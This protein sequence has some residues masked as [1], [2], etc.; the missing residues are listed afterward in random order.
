M[1]SR[2]SVG[3]AG[4]CK[5]VEIMAASSNNGCGRVLGL[6]CMGRYR[7]GSNLVVLFDFFS[8]FSLLNF[9]KC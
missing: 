9:S 6:L 1:V 5:I 7:A 3:W 4:L 2:V 8:F